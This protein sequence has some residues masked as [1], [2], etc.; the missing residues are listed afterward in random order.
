MLEIFSYGFMVRAL[1]V[2]VLVALCAALVGVPL[3]LRRNSM[4]GDGLSHVAFGA[5]ALAVVL[6]WTPL[7]FALPVV[8]LAS[9]FALKLSKSRQ[10]QGD[11]VIAVLSASSLAIGTLVISLSKGVNIDLNGYLFGSILSVGVGDVVLSV[12]LALIVILLYVLAYHRIFAITFDEDFAKSV[13]VRTGLYE[14]VFAMCCSAVVVLGMR[15][16][17]SLLISSLIIFPT[18][19]AMR[20]TRTFKQVV[21]L[22]AAVSVIAF[23]I[24]LILSYLLA[25][26]TGATVVLINMGFLILAS[27][28]GSLRGR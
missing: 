18:L 4:I 6:G 27:I 12:I 5:F 1:A 25:T 28:F 20:L 19:I 8:I 2:G 24:G 10:V 7:W 3:V 9:F 11:A 14:A 22:A 15:L 17:G 23:T 16:L 21:I 13:G 26:P